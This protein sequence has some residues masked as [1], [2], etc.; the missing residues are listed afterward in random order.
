MS[1]IALG[2][3]KFGS[4]YEVIRP[5]VVYTELIQNLMINDPP[6]DFVEIKKEY[7]SCKNKNTIYWDKPEIKQ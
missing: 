6:G 4:S 3:L 5:D 7:F 2:C 1:S